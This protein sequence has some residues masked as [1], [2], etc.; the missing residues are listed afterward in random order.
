MLLKALESGAVQNS[1]GIQKQSRNSER[2]VRVEV[3]CVLIWYLYM[4]G[5]GE[6]RVSKR[7]RAFRPE[8]PSVGRR[9]LRAVEICLPPYVR[10]DYA[11]TVRL[12]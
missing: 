7:L 3:A 6:E 2:R 10:C 5:A 8:E 11:P 4:F 12:E 1:F 9:V